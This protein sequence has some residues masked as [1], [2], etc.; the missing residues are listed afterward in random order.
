MEANIT[1]NVDY[2]LIADYLHGVV[3]T[4][5]GEEQICAVSGRTIAENLSVLRNAS[6]LQGE[7]ASSGG[8]S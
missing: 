3:D 4:L 5:A 8:I 6:V 1:V 7:E 2:K